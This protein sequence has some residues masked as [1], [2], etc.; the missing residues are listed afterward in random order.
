[1]RRSALCV[2]ALFVCVAALA[3]DK[4]SG[5]RPPKPDVPYL[6]H[7]DTLVPTEAS[8]AK[9]E[10][11][12][13]DSAYTVPGAASPARTPMAEPVFLFLS[14]KI[15]PDTLQLYRLEVKNGNRQ[16]VLSQKRRGGSRPMRLMVT[17]L[18]D[19]LYRLE[20]DEGLGLENG[21]YSL[22][23]TGSNGVFCFQV[24]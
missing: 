15:Q 20:V 23:P 3:A 10:S 13:D 11:H 4:Y 18:D 5:P 16:V 7:A 1:M 9:E 6:M 8:E 2:L 17:R 12:K 14:D 22:S 19:K 24:Y 21:E